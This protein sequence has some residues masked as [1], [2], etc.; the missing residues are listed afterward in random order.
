MYNIKHCQT[1]VN[2][3]LLHFEK[4]L[5]NSLLIVNLLQFQLCSITK[6]LQYIVNTS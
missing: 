4:Y 2:A 6:P 5:A 3:L 1:L